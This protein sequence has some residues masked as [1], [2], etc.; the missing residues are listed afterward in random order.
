[1]EISKK[2]NVSLFIDFNWLE[3]IICDTGPGIAKEFLKDV[4]NPFFTTWK[5]QEH[6]GLGLS[7]ADKI[8]QAHGGCLHIESEPG[9][10]TTVTIYLP[11]S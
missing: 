7:I 8:I 11:L 10:G 2:K 9:E 3:I 5:D 4:R 1:M 6:V